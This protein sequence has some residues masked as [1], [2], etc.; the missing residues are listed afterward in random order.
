MT[1]SCSRPPRARPSTLT[2]H[3]REGGKNIPSHVTVTKDGE[4]VTDYSE[5]GTYNAVNLRGA[6]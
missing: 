3:R 1:G 6:R 2:V 4:T 5:P